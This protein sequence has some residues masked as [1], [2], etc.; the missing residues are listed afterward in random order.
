V[1]DEQP[2]ALITGAAGDIGRAAAR[3]LAQQGWSLSLVDHPSV[4]AA[5]DE[6][7]R[8]CTTLGAPA[9]IDTFDVIDAA[10]VHRS[11]HACR[12]TIGVPT[13]L[14][15]N[16]GY[17]GT[18]ERIDRYPYD[19]AQRVFEVNVIG[20]FTVL[21][22]VSAAM[23][24]AGVPGSIVS[25]ASM[26][27]V[28]GAPNMSAYS[29]SKAAIIGLTKSAA[30]DLAPAG[31]RVN[32]V[33]PAFIGPGRMW[34]NQ[35]ASQTAAPSPYYADDPSEVARQMIRTVPLGRYGSTDEVARVVSFLLSDD[36]SYVTGINIEISGGSV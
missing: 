22:A 31:I 21:S 12:D 9:W 20:A 34:D 3:R 5:L 36:A 25:S 28:T 18:F 27:G 26:A 2:I 17:Q 13:A 33:S 30:K 6:T 8:E 16:A 10:A 15:N 32:A 11:V 23:V 35:V 1:G 19:D 14:F 29:A 7:R 4:W 24:A